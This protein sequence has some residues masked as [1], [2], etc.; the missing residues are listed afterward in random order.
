MVTS[1]PE[2]TV[3]ANDD[4]SL[5]AL[6]A[7]HRGALVRYF[8]RRGYPI[9]VAEDYVQDVF[10]R[11]ARSNLKN[12][13][14]FEAYLFVAASNVAISHGRKLRVRHAS[15]HDSIH[16][17]EL[18]SEEAS[19]ARVLEGKE[20]LSRLRFFLSEMKPRTREIFLL[21]R[22]HGL[23]YT[24]L[25]TRFGL[26]VSAVEKHMSNALAHIRQRFQRHD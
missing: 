2:R 16:N 15:E 14:N 18:D 12:V 19:P 5:E 7:R 24:Q 1:N 17:L 8:E 10:I 13:E 26:S 21:N 22:L 4:T 20:A 9:D 23:N 25:A 11:I 6:F 3:T